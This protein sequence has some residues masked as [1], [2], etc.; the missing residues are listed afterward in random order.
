MVKYSLPVHCTEK[1]RLTLCFKCHAKG[2]F[3]LEFVCVHHILGRLGQLPLMC[4]TSN[5]AE[6]LME[7][8][9]MM[10]TS[11]HETELQQPVTL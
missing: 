2:V 10:A 6:I 7:G 3:P 11:V 9:R 8:G 5:E 4:H 1:V